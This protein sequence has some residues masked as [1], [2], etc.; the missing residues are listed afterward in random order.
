MSTPSIRAWPAGHAAPRMW[1]KKANWNGTAR[2]SG[3][4]GPQAAWQAASLMQSRPVAMTSKAD[5]RWARR[6]G[7]RAGEMCRFPAAL[8]AI[9]PAFHAIMPGLSIMFQGRAFSLI[10]WST[11]P[12]CP[13]IT[14]RA[15]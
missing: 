10:M 3:R 11:S 6:R 7:G 12:P 9:L 4:A 14:A 5:S 8:P 1:R 2:V 15:E 13:A